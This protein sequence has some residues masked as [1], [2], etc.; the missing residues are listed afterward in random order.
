[1]MKYRDDVDKKFF[2]LAKRTYDN[3]NDIYGAF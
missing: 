2:Q 1:L 3:Y